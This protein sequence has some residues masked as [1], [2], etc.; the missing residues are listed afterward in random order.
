M[1]SGGALQFQ[2][3]KSSGHTKILS[4]KQQKIISVCMGHRRN[5]QCTKM[6]ETWAQSYRGNY[7]SQ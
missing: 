6:M 7:L 2:A 4:C 5:L 1:L 3:K